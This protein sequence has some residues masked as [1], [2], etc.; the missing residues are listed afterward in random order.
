VLGFEIAGEVQAVGEQVAAYQPGDAVFGSTFWSN[1]GGYAQYKCLPEGGV[2]A[3]KPVNITFEE[4]AAGFASGGITAL[5]IL[6]KADIQEGQQMLVNGASGGVGVFSVQ[7][8]KIFG[9]Q[10]TGVCS[11]SNMELVSSL[12]ADQVIDYTREDFTQGDQRYDVVFDAV[13]KVS[14]AKAKEALKPGGVYLNVMKHTEDKSTAADLDFLREQ[15]EAGRLKTVVDRVYPL[16]E[17]VEAHRYV[18]G[19]HK[20]GNVVVTV[21]HQD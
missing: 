8:A 6:R 20:R 10:V 1:F 3:P 14:P 19:G 18:Q 16:E 12:G 17:I 5:G 13:A 7:L 15:V 9:A 11:T 2:L 21:S 4:A